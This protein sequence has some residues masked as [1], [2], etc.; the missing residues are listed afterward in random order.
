MND[1]R[2][3]FDGLLRDIENLQNDTEKLLESK[4]IEELETHLTDR[5]AMLSE[6]NLEVIAT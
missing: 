5:I 6:N 1:T 4:G 3:V 2:A